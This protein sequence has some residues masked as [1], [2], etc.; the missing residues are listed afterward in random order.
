MPFRPYIFKTDP[1]S[2]LPILPDF[3]DESDVKQWHNVTITYDTE[4]MTIYD[5]G[6]MIRH[7][8]SNTNVTHTNE[9]DNILRRHTFSSSLIDWFTAFGN[10]E[11]SHVDYSLE[12]DVRDISVTFEA[13]TATVSDSIFQ[14]EYIGLDPNNGKKELGIF[15][16]NAEEFQLLMGMKPP[17]M[18]PDSKTLSMWIATRIIND[19]RKSNSNDSDTSK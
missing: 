17:P 12:K 15:K 19:I 9:D 3:D 10:H 8:I 16:T 4:Q 13:G 7:P 18:E 1:I 5:N 11:H 6:V 2:D 14:A